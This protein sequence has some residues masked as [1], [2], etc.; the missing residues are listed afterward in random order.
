[1][2]FLSWLWWWSCFPPVNALIHFECRLLALQRLSNRGVECPRSRA[3]RKIYGARQ[4]ACGVR[5]Q[6][7][8]AQAANPP[9]I[10]VASNQT[11]VGTKKG[12]RPLRDLRRPDFSVAP[13]DHQPY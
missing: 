2:P 5:R 6:R 8:N 10:L 1:M 11:L 4:A 12:R 13:G 3:K 7:F 9:H